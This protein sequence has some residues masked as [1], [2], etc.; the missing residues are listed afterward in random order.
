MPANPVVITDKTGGTQ[1]GT[2]TN[3]LHTTGGGG[4]GDATAANQ[5][6][7]N[8]S[9]SSIDGKTPALVTGRVPV[10][11]SG[12]TQPVSGTVGVSGSVAVTGPLTDAQLR[13]VPVPVSTG[14]LTDVELRAT[15]VPV[16]GTITANAGT[17]TM[18]VSAASLPLPSGAATA[19]LQTQPGVD[20]GDVTVNNAAGA[21]AVNIQDGGNTITVDGTVTANA[22]TN[23]NTSLLSLETTQT[24]MSAKLPATLGQKA[25][26]AS[27]AVVLASDQASVP[28]AAT[29]P[30]GTL[31]IGGTYPVGGQVIDEVPTVRTV[32]RTSITAS[33]SGAT[34]VVAAQGGGIRIRVLS[35]FVC[36]STAVGVKFQSAST[37]ISGL[38][39]LA[40]NGGF[41]MPETSH[42]WFQTAANEALNV[43]LSGAATSVGVTVV[44]VQAT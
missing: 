31:R 35:V 39:A 43:N 27:L 25:M 9:L 23:L 44:W 28:V 21:S 16:S 22:G 24:A 34:V 10:D 17:G 1:L 7:G 30:A 2:A 36:T 29:L 18:A 3:P 26:A 41:V 14:G 37:D 12:V 6:I 13:A 20:I 32:N 15:P 38:S 40:A 5:V 42:G 8:A 4:G 19:A 11:G 33:A